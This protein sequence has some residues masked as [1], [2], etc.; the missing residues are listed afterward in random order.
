MLSKTRES[1]SPAWFI[2]FADLNALLLG[3]FMLLYAFSEQDKAKFKQVA[4]SMRDAFGVQQEVRVREPPKGMSVIAREFS[5]GIPQPTELD[6]VRQLTTR[7]SLPQPAVLEPKKPVV[8]RSSADD[9]R[10]IA[11]QESLQNALRSEIDA[12]L[13]ELEIEDDRIVLRIKEKGAF[14]SGSDHLEG[15]FKPI[16]QRLGNTLIGTGGTIIVAGHTDSIPIENSAFRSNWELST[17]RALSVAQVFFDCSNT[18][19]PRVHLESYAEFRPIDSNDTPEG[20]AR[21]RRVEISLIHRVDPLESDHRTSGRH[22]EAP[23]EGPLLQAARAAAAAGPAPA[24]AIGLGP[25][26]ARSR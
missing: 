21:N 1:R 10:R 16:V 13:I 20:R 17:A 25:T 8:P 2:T 5:P 22:S 11:D 26:A 19:M 6:E 14:P 9:A 12:G 4:G 3:F 24:D 23:T 7:D 15:A 18:L